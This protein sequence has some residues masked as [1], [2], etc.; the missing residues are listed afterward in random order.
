MTEIEISLGARG[1]LLVVLALALLCIV[2]LAA[3]G[4]LANVRDLRA[5]VML[6]EAVQ[7]NALKHRPSPAEQATRHREGQADG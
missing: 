4:M 7:D 5:R 3:L 1:L 6:L 2:A